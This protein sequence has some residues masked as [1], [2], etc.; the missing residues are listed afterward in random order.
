M[1]EVAADETV[2]ERVEHIAHEETGPRR[3][4]LLAREM[5][6]HRRKSRDDE[7]VDDPW[8]AGIGRVGNDPERIIGGM[9]LPVEDSTK[10]LPLRRGT[11]A[12]VVTE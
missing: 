6:E 4:I 7:V 3:K 8:N 12:H 11:A 9:S 10:R 5:A 1:E 2:N